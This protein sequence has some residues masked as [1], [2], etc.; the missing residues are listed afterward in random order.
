MNNFEIKTVIF[1]GYKSAY[2]DEGNGE[3]IIFLHNAGLSHRL[4][5]KGVGKAALI[6]SRYY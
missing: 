5:G 4:F 6:T 3:P 1:R 2:I